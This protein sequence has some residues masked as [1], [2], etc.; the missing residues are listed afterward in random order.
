MT[1]PALQIH[2][3]SWPH[4][5]DQMPHH[6]LSRAANI[7]SDRAYAIEV[8]AF[9]VMATAPISEQNAQYLCDDD[10]V[11][12]G[13]LGIGGGCSMVYD[14]EGREIAEPLDEH[15]EGIVY[16][17]VDTAKYALAKSALD[18]VG[19]YGR[20]D[21]FRVTFDAEPRQSVTLHNRDSHAKQQFRKSRVETF[22]AAPQRLSEDARAGL[23]V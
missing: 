23:G 3:A 15:G 11:K 21:V 9:V 12:R 22:S 2:C 19:H 5:H 17:M 8:G 18:T 13:M 7:G 10:H 4:L 6:S 1:S 14:P 20:E 16:A